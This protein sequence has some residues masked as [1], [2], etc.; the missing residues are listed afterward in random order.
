MLLICGS[1]TIRETL[2]DGNFAGSP[3]EAGGVAGVAHEGMLHAARLLLENAEFMALLRTHAAECA[4]R[5]RVCGHSLGGGISA[6]VTLLLRDEFPLVTGAGIGVPACLSAELCDSLAG[7]F[8]SVV[9]DADVVPRLSAHVMQ[10]LLEDLARSTEDARP[11]VRSLAHLVSRPRVIFRVTARVSHRLAKKR[12]PKGA[13]DEAA[14]VEGGE[15][16]AAAA[17]WVPGTVWRFRGGCGHKVS[18]T[19]LDELVLTAAAFLAHI[20]DQYVYQ[21]TREPVKLRP[22]PDSSAT[23]VAAPNER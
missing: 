17:M 15:V 21:M 10:R 9:N 4:G 23:G 7:C 3:L 2:V 6:I 16:A 20:P 19:A 1:M 11:V 8:D 18:R 12:D 22:L 14:A 5:V 13:A